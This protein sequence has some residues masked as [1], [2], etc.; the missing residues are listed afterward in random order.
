MPELTLEILATPI[1]S[2][3]CSHRSSDRRREPSVIVADLAHSERLVK[4]QKRNTMA[5]V[6]RLQCTC[7]TLR[8]IG[9]KVHIGPAAVQPYPS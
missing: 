4:K 1:I 7:S 6:Q 9:S 3:M 2:L 5:K 8:L